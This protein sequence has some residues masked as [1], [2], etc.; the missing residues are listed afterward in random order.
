MDQP[1]VTELAAARWPAAGYSKRLWF[2]QLEAQQTVELPVTRWWRD[3][4]TR[5][6]R[7]MQRSSGW[8]MNDYCDAIYHLEIKQTHVAGQSEHAAYGRNG[9]THLESNPSR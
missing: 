8:L 5:F 1:E 6:I 3:E 2:I 4:L 7:S 9:K